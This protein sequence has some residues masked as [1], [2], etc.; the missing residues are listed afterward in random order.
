MEYFFT[1]YY[2]NKLLRAFLNVIFVFLVGISTILVQ[3]ISSNIQDA[4]LTI[5]SIIFPLIAGFLTFGKELLKSITK[6]I[7]EIIQDD[8]DNVGPPTTDFDKGKIAD[9]SVMASNFTDVILKIFRFAFYLIV[10]II[11][12][13]FND[14]NF[15]TEVFDFN[16]YTYIQSN[17]FA[18][19]LKFVFFY[20]LFQLL[21]YTFYF[22]VFISEIT[23]NNQ[24][25]Q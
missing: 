25:L 11:I 16:F 19:I 23:K 15:K 7:E 9:L 3:S 2:E 8:I 10:F 13:K 21:F 1:K 22:M 24:S 18:L 4:F 6:K 20:F 12:T 17:Y 5:L 14:Y